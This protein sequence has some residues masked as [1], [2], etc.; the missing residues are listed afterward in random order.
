VP[1]ALAVKYPHVALSRGWQWVF[2]SSNVSQDAR[3]GLRLRQ[4]MTDTTIQKSVAVA[5][6]RADI[7]KPSSPHIVRRSFATDLSQSGQ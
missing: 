6:K 4:H 1:D 5:S 7:T 2:S 3:T